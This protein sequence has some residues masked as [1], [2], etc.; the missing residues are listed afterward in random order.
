[1]ALSLSCSRKSPEFGSLELPGTSSTTLVVIPGTHKLH[2]VKLLVFRFCLLNLQI[3]PTRDMTP[4]VWLLMS[5]VLRMH[6]TPTTIAYPCCRRQV[7]LRYPCCRVGF[8][9]S[10]QL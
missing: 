2:P 1:M 4:L 8:P 7:C 9:A 6:R 5:C 10:F 3:R